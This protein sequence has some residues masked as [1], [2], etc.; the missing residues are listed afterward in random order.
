MTPL[1]LSI[2]RV[3]VGTVRVLIEAGA[4][5]EAAGESNLTA[6]E[7]AV[8]ANEDMVE[9]ITEVRATLEA[10]GGGRQEIEIKGENA[11]VFQLIFEAEAARKEARDRALRSIRDALGC[12]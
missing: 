9:S 3:D 2:R 1:Q 11:A 7:F 4:S 12:E 10:A 5:L 6:L 8:L